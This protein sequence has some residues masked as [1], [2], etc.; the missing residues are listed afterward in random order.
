MPLAPWRSPLDRALDQNR[1]LPYARYLQLATVRTD[2]RPANRT[3]VF[4]GF[5]EGTDQ[6]KLVVDARSQKSEQIDRQ[7]W[8]E[9]CWYF[10]ET[11]EQFRISGSLRLIGDTY[12]EPI[13]QARQTTWQKLSDSTRLQFIW[14][15]PGAVRSATTAFAT[16]PPDSTNPPKCFCLLLLQPVQVDH[17]ELRG[18]PQNRWLYRYEDSQTWSTEAINP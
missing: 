18:E 14:P 8:G 12:P 11:R 2:G 15:E 5:L 3:L 16:T 17:L 13:Q 4:R 10:A 7:P 9:V 1:S 6:L